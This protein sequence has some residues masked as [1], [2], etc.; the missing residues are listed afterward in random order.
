M[1][2]IAK[3]ITFAADMGKQGQEQPQ[4]VN[5]HFINQLYE[6][7]PEW[8]WADEDLMMTNHVSGIPMSV[9]GNGQPYQQDYLHIGIMTDGEQD[10]KVNMQHHHITP[11]TVLIATEGSILQSENY[12]ANLDSQIIHISN[13]LLQRVFQGN[14]PPMISHRMYAFVLRFDDDEWEMLLSIARS[15]WLSVHT[16]HHLSSEAVLT[17][18]LEYL[19]DKILKAREVE[20]ASIPRNIQYTNRF[21]QLVNEHCMEHR[22]LKFYA[23][24]LYLNKQYL[25]SVISS[26]TH[27]SARNWIEEATATRIKVMLRHSGNMTMNEIAE[28]F[29]FSEPSHFSRYFKRLTG[30]TPA[31]YRKF[32]V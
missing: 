5:R 28:Q 32:D 15:L 6:N 25:S 27:R 12:S 9:F 10:M 24:K 23:D 21:I 29:A 16:D 31:Q 11:Q 8:Q 13:Q 4:H 18:L 1:A 20:R 26:V 22:D 2:V 14:V 7:Y 19:R 17:A 30:M 3:I